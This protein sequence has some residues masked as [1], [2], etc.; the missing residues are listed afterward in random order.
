MQNIILT[1]YRSHTLKMLIAAVLGILF[2]LIDHAVH[3]A[4]GWSLQLTWQFFATIF[5][6]RPTKL[7][8]LTTI[9]AVIYDTLGGVT[10]GYTATLMLILQITTLCIHNAFKA[11]PT[12]QKTILMSFLLLLTA[13][14]DWILSCVMLKQWIPFIPALLHR[15][16]MALSFPMFYGLATHIARLLVTYE[17]TQSQKSITRF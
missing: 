13:I 9:I 1:I 16:P 7:P 17:F 3:T 10:I 14:P 2:V 4:F 6:L 11:S 12:L 8:F 5:I 15:I